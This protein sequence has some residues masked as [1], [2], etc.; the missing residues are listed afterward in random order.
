M[1]LCNDLIVVG[2]KF[3]CS[4]QFHFTFNFT[5]MDLALLTHADHSILS[6]GT[7]GLWGALLANDGEV[8]MPT[9]YSSHRINFEIDM[10]KATGLLKK[11]FYI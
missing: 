1:N 11:W 3:V 2:Y 9:G 8:C 5:G 7:F 6:Y 4:N 10:A